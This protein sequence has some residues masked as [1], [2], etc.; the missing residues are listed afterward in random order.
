MPQIAY[1]T[2]QTDRVRM[3]VR[4]SQHDLPEDKRL[5][6]GYRINQDGSISFDRV[7]T[8]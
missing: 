7:T 6:H 4:K 3:S 2:N 1:E 5:D 8:D